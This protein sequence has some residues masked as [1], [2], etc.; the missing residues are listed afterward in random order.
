MLAD[1]SAAVLFVWS[2]GATP[3][4]WAS[5]A[6]TALTTTGIAVVFTPQILS[7]RSLSHPGFSPVCRDPSPRCS[8]HARLPHLLPRDTYLV[9]SYTLLLFAG[10]CVRGCFCILSCN[11]TAA[12]FRVL[13]CLKNQIK[14]NLFY[15][16][17]KKSV[18]QQNMCQTEKRAID[19][20]LKT[21][22]KIS[23]M[24]RNVDM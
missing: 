7:N 23:K 17:I 9:A 22:Q 10:L 4:A 24:I 14:S 8:C 5:Q 3:P 20:E 19:N 13:N 16:Q 11:E 12:L 1:V 2:A 18:S 6:Q 15:F 21:Q